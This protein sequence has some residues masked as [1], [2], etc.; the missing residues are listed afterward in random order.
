MK[1]SKKIEHWDDE[2]NLGNGIILTL[3]W[4]WSFEPPKHG[5][6]DHEGVKGFD[7]PK[8]ANDAAKGAFRCNCEHCKK[9]RG[10]AK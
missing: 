8:E 9:Y 6:P 3:R 4:G 1:R 7:T 10:M 2:R 5:I